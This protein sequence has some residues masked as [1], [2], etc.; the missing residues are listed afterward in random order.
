MQRLDF[1][2]HF[3]TVDIIHTNEVEIKRCNLKIQTGFRDTG[4]LPFVDWHNLISI[5]LPNNMK[6]YNFSHLTFK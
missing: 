4:N 1:V 6:I 2:T 5:K 3:P